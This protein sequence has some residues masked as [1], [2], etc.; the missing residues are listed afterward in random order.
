VK[1][2][3]KTNKPYSNPFIGRSSKRR[4]AW[5]RKRKKW[6]KE[7]NAR[8]EERLRRSGLWNAQAAQKGRLVV[9]RVGEQ[10]PA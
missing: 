2:N 8:A 7:F 4:K 1:P 9:Y 3:T 6:D 10:P 5:L